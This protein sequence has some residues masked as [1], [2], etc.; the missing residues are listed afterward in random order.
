MTSADV[1]VETAE[2]IARL[3]SLL[4]HPLRIR[5][6]IAL[7]TIGPSSAT[8]LSVQ[9]GGVTVGDC[10]YHLM[11]L[12]D[13]GAIKLVRSRAVRG[14]TERVYCLAPQTRASRG[15]THLRHFIDL[16]MPTAISA[17]I[18]PAVTASADR[19]QEA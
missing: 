8:A 3:A 14:A 1:N 10:H 18:A 9:L 13:G 7:A 4:N 12:R 11:T 15:A 2:E 6:M 19:K 5:L 17:E 16:V